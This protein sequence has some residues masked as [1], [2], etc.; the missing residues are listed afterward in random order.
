MMPI[1]AA[2]AMRKWFVLI[3][4]TSITVRINGKVVYTTNFP[5]LG[6]WGLVSG[7]PRASTSHGQA[8]ADKVPD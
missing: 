6:P 8:R 7:I 4:T 3:A 5:S 1:N 2:N